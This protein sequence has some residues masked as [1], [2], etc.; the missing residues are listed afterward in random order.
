MI[1]TLEDLR[2]AQA[3][4]DSL[5]RRSDNYSG[6]NPDK[7]RTSIGEAGA[8]VRAI[9]A[10]LKR[11]GLLERS[12]QEQLE[13]ELDVAFPK[14]ASKQVVEFNGKRY[15]RRFTPRRRSLSGKTVKEWT[16]SWEAV[17]E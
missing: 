4:L 9:E 1:Y 7:Y 2:A 10:E 5:N 11:T 17:P 15:M 8:K 14:A 13:H 12:P 6:N 3:E 16:G